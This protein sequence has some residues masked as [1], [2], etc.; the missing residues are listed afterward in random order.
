MFKYM[1]AS[2][3]AKAK[4]IVTTSSTSLAPISEAS[5]ASNR[6]A[7]IFGCRPNDTVAD[8]GDGVHDRCW[9]YSFVFV[10]VLTPIRNLTHLTFDL[11]KHIVISTLN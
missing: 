9:T 10:R 4:D 11:A 2:T 7:F 6:T 8:K 5:E 3:Q 1:D